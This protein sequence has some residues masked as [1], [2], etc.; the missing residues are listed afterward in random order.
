MA[1]QAENIADLVVATLRELGRGKW[2]DLASDLQEYHFLPQIL[3][4]ER[5]QF[6]GGYGIRR[7]IMVD[8]AHSAKH[9]GLFAIDD[10]NVPDLM[11]TITMEWRHTTTSWAFDER[12]PEMNSGAEKIYDVVKSRRAAAMISLAELMEETF[13]ELGDDFSDGLTPAG[14]YYW[15]TKY[16]S[17][18]SSP[19]SGGFL[20]GNPVDGGGTELTA[21]A[22]GLSSDDYAK[23]KN[24]A[25]KYTSVTK[26]DLIALMR[27][28]ARY[29][30]FKAP[31]PMPSYARGSDRKG[32]YTNYDVLGTMERLAEAQNENLGNDLASKDGDVLFHGRPVQW[33]PQLD[34]DAGDPVFG[35]NWSEFYPY[36]LKGEYLKDSGPKDAPQQHRVKN[37]FVDLTWNTV[38]TNRR[39]QFV[40]SKTDQ[41]GS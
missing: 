11:Q 34:D 23:W 13:W 38:C 25:G 14:I 20:G 19:A 12:E 8:H 32:F 4:K 30:K 22:G 40:L 27:K 41:T 1:L 28:A 29:T 37:M 26:D 15:I 39:K 31:V 16:P 10:V 17:G 3:K 33:V 35:V 5:V 36:F 6:S 2:T 9:T 7:T 21:G 24:Y 18:A